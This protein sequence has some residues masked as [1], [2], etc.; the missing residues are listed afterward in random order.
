LKARLDDL[1]AENS[2][3][4]TKTDEQ[5]D[6]VARLKSELTKAEELA[7]THRIEAETRE[8]DMQQ[9]LQSS[10]DALHGESS[11]LSGLVFV[12]KGPLFGLIACSFL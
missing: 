12:P 3:L 9:C 2:A 7:R 5:A 6:E 1:A 8:K 4:K 11:T 10:L